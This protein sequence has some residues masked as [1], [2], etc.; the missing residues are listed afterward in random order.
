MRD[1]DALLALRPD[2]PTEPGAGAVEAFQNDTLRPILRLQHEPLIAAWHRYASRNKGTFYRLN[3]PQQR[4]YVR[5]AIRTNRELRSFLLGLVCGVMTRAE[6]AAFRQN[7]RE[8]ARRVYALATERL[9]G[10]GE[11]YARAAED[12]GD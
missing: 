6:W 11:S 8:L 3:R 1:D 4:D 5:H 9:L 2:V 7:E 12:P 10:A